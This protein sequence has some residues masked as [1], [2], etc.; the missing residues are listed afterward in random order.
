MAGAPQGYIGRNPSDGRTT[1]NRQTFNVTSGVQTSFTFTSGYDLG[2]LDVYLNGVK[3]NETTDYTA[4]DGS[5]FSFASSTPAVQGD[6]LEA[7]AYKSFNTTNVTGSTRDFLVGRN[8]DVSGNVTIGSSLTVASDLIVNGT[9]TYVNTEILDIEDKT[10]GIASTSAASNTT[11]DGAGIVVY[12]GSDGDK[13]FLWNKTKSNWVLVGGGVSIGTGCTIGSSTANVLEFSVDGAVNAKL[14]NYGAWIVGDG[15][16]GEAWG[17][18]YKTVQAGTGAF[19]GNSPAASASSYWTTNAYFDAV[20]SRWE[21][22]AGDE[23]SRFAQGDGSLAYYNAGSGSADGAITWTERF[24]VTAAGNLG[25]GTDTPTDAAHELNTA[26]LN[27][28]ILTATT[29]YGDGSNLTNLV[30]GLTTDTYRNTSGGIN[31]LDSMTAG[32]ATDNTAVGYDAG[33]AITT[34]D[35]NTAFGSYAL[36]ANTTASHNTAVGFN[37]LLTNTTGGSNLAVGY[38]AVSYTHLRAHET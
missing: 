37:A 21:Y 7:I 30:A 32:D 24:R 11:A 34:G 12:G 19:G 29:L 4:A 5:T 1:I 22:I 35:Y 38:D 36:A 31:A 13:S 17:D 33:T 6:T 26:I 10:V 3:Q 25:V 18:N 27:V 15:V 9:Y 2:Y 28:G 8:L 14:N 20:N 16:A 23:A